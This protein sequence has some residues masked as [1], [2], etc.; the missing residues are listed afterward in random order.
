MYMPSN[1]I[2]VKV[3]EAAGTIVLNRPDYGNALTRSMVQQLIEA[4]DDLYLEKRVR[5]IIITG[6][7]DHFSLGA[8]VGE[9]QTSQES[10]APEEDWGADADKCRQFCAFLPFIHQFAVWDG[11]YTVFRQQN[12]FEIGRAHV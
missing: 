4:I 8:D 2:D 11:V 12:R 1:A 3:Y 7:G 5:A 10:E 9:M 6:A